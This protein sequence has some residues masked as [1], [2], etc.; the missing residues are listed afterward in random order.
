[1]S[2]LSPRAAR[3]AERARDVNEAQQVLRGRSAE[4]L[5]TYQLAERLKNGNE[6]GY[7]RRLYGRVRAMGDDP[8]LRAKA[9]RVKLGQRHAL[10]TYKDQDLPAADR[11]KRALEILDEVDGC[12]PA[13]PELQE[14]LGLR[15]AVYKRMWQ[16]HG[17]SADL[18][19]AC[20]YYLQ[21]YAMGPEND[22]GYTGINAAFVLELL[23]REAA[24]EASKTGQGWAGVDDQ[25]NRARQI[26]A[27]LAKLLPGLPALPNNAYLKEA[28]WFY[29]TR[30]EAHFGLG[31]YKEGLAALR[32]FNSALKLPNQNPPVDRL[33]PWEFESTMTQF[34]AL[35]QTQAELAE[36]LK[37]RPGWTSP[38]P[39]P[40][41]ELR[42]RASAALRDYLGDLAH[43]V[44]R[45]VRGKVGLGLS[46]G[47]FRASLFHIGVLA[48][49]A[50]RDILRHVE[51]LSCVSGGSI[52]GAHYYLEV[53][54]L[55][56]QKPDGKVTRE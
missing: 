10:C 13:G 15:G 27:M 54:R 43:G 34:A 49:L 51:V 20:G 39:F 11:F 29:T 17:Q 23:A 4:P 26:R 46:G 5:A 21:G 18:T 53:K 42:G 19:R 45:V 48:H 14:S 28:W 22:Q 6:F 31:E 16:V 44:D 7:A 9:S 38:W 37:S 8:A 12:K 24:I 33:A 56:E 41:D 50:E 3:D 35:I 52:V 1:M 40:V 30:A 36:Q 2:A 32:E 47:G 55:L 25:M